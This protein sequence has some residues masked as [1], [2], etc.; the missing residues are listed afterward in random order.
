MAELGELKVYFALDLV[1]RSGLHFP[2]FYRSEI[3]ITVA[4]DLGNIDE[5]R[6]SFSLK[7][8]LSVLLNRGGFYGDYG[9]I[10]L[11]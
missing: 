4:S 7:V 6:F 9:I 8:A 1:W 10:N 11:N 2:S 3:L 5:R